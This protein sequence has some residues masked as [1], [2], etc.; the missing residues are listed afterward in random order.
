MRDPSL[1]LDFVNARKLLMPMT[2]ARRVNRRKLDFVNAAKLILLVDVRGE[3]VTFA[4]RRDDD[5]GRIVSFCFIAFR[6]R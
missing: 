6:L 4:G 5:A 3:E 2:F 1:A